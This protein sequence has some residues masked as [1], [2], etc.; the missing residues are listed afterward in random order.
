MFLVA[1]KIMVII[2]LYNFYTFRKNM[3]QFE[4]HIYVTYLDDPDIA[5]D[6]GIDAGW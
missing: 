6:N 2:H 3:L 5:L 4:D 1:Y